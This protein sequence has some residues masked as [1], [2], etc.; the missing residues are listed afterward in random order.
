MIA[1]VAS[2]PSLQIKFQDSQSYY[3]MSSWDKGKAVQASINLFGTKQSYIVHHQRSFNQSETLLI[4][5]HT[6]DPSTL[7]TEASRFLWVQGKSGLQG[8][9]QDSQG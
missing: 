2:Q 8:E 4:L 3:F 6:F 1:T 5:A 7:E 9:F